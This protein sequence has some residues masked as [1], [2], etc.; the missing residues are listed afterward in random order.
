MNL[1]SPVRKRKPNEPADSP[2]PKNKAKESKKTVR[3]KVDH[4]DPL[5]EDLEKAAEYAKKLQ[6]EIPGRTYP[7]LFSSASASSLS[8]FSLLLFSPSSL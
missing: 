1:V 8:F 5:K 3:Y 7:L 4:E 2:G 6:T